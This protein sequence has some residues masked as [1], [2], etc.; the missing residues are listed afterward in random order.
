[1]NEDLQHLAFVVDCTPEIM[2]PAT[3]PDEHLVE[4]AIAESW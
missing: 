4:R 3:D 1:L 2:D